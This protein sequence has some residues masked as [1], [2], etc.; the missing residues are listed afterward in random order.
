M[1]HGALCSGTWGNFL[2][3]CLLTGGADAGRGKAAAALARQPRGAA[4]WAG[5]QGESWSWDQ[6]LKS[7]AAVGGIHKAGELGGGKQS[8]PRCASATP[9]ALGAHAARSCV[10]SAAACPL[11]YPRCP[12][13]R[14]LQPAGARPGVHPA[15]QHWAV[16]QPGLPALPCGVVAHVGVGVCVHASVHVHVF[17]V[18]VF[19][20]VPPG[21]PQPALLLWSPACSAPAV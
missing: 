13:G 4:L 3:C 14:R 7:A 11:P 1:L 6:E 21:L 19:C 18:C 2:D 12:A 16:L 9:R 15:A 17:C 20:I 5:A 8:S 10:R